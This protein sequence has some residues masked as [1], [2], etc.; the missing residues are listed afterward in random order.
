HFGY[1]LLFTVPTL[2]QL[3]AQSP[4]D[5]IRKEFLNPESKKVLVASHRAVHHQYPENSIPAIREAIRLNIDIIE[6]DVQVSS[7]GIPMLMHDQKIDMTTNGTGNLETQEFKELE[8]LRLR[9]GETLTDEHIPPLEEVLLLAKG[10]IL[11]DLD[12]KTG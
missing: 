7:D 12:L 1:A 4:S 6:I 8:K 9:S 10:K 3:H 2:T 11:V 5:K